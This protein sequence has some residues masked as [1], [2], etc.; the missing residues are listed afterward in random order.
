MPRREW[1]AEEREKLGLMSREEMAKL[2]PSNR[3][4]P[5]E[6]QELKERWEAT[7]NTP[8]GI[9]AYVNYSMG[10]VLNGLLR[11]GEGEE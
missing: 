1:T 4:T 6:R 9:K 2:P 10:V 8:E 5:E 3:L 7:P 11:Q